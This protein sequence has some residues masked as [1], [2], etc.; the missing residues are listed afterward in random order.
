VTRTP[1]RHRPR[2]H[3][4]RELRVASVDPEVAVAVATNAT[5]TITT[6]TRRIARKAQS[7][8]SNAAGSH[9]LPDLL[10]NALI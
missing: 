2:R 10:E 8:D 1:R 9:P 3:R 5:P 6:I 7:P 4:Q